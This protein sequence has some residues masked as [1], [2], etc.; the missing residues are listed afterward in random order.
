MA[1]Y[2]PLMSAS[3]QRPV[4]TYYLRPQ[5]V[6][7]LF[8]FVILLTGFLPVLYPLLCIHYRIRYSNVSGFFSI[9]FSWIWRPYS[10]FDRN[11]V[12]FFT[13]SPSDCKMTALL[14]NSMTSPLL[15]LTAIHQPP[16]NSPRLRSCLMYGPLRQI[17]K[18][19]RQASCHVDNSMTPE[20]H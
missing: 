19:K 18:N 5:V 10:Q 8:S 4:S 11:F 12:A 20:N 7:N 16:T 1:K 15:I 13:P 3:Q 14:L 17:G 9:A 6:L 2:S